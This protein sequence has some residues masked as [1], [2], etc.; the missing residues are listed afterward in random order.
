MK[1]PVIYL[2][3]VF[4]AGILVYGCGKKEETKVE[5]KDD[6]AAKIEDWTLTK[7]FLYRYIDKLP[8][9]KKEEYNTPQG[10]AELTEQIM[11]DE[12]FYREALRNDMEARDDVHKQIENAKRN[13]LI[14]AYYKEYVENRARPSEEELL[15][16]YN[17]HQDAYTTLPAVR[18]AHI[19]SESKERLE[20][21]KARIEAGEKFTTLARKYSEDKLTGYDGGDLGYFNPGGY[22]RGVGFSE[23]F[24]DTVFKMEAK[25]LYGP[26]KWDK[27]YSLVVVQEKK[28]ARLREFSEV[29]KE[30]SDQLM[31]Q[32]IERVKRQV[33]HEIS[34]NYDWNNYMEEYYLSIQRTPEE[35]F[36]YAQSAGD[37]YE[38]I[39]AFEEIVEKFPEDQHA[40]QA[41]FMVG[42]VHLE[43]LHD[44]KSATFTFRKVL[45]MYPD[46]DVADSAEWMLNNMDKP[47]PEFEKVKDLNKKL[48]DG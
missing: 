44:K 4:L 13:I 10:R 16:Y 46:S 31:R 8:A 2:C 9:N 17:S 38:R 11:G 37:P 6:L 18:A 14:Q 1:R 36:E 35:L 25:K 21:L 48:S 32:N 3:L 40:P 43:E 15:Q 22:I 30:I 20:D 29:R 26:I 23:A 7:D 28:P 5:N 19:F 39:R 41:L 27:G 33:I 34:E 45:D 24:S 12:F 47:M 42:F